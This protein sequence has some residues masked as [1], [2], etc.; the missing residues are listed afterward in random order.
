MWEGRDNPA[1]TILPQDQLWQVPL[2]PPEDILSWLTRIGLLQDDEAE[3]SED[4]ATRGESLLEDEFDLDEDAAPTVV[5][6]TDERG[7]VMSDDMLS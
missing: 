6:G 7:A 1:C 4:G 3:E 2:G 5:G